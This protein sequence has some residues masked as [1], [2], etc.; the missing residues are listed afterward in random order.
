MNQAKRAEAVALS[1]ADKTKAPVLVAKGYGVAAESILK[2]ARESGLYI[3]S[4]T[5]LVKLH[6]HV[7]MDKQIP[8]ELYRAVAEVMVWMH[9][10]EEGALQD[11]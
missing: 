6:M 8:P 10:L 2:G 1:H 5:D 4:S 11:G 7:D 9:R 3:H